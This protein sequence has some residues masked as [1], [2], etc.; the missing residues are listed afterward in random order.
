MYR[1][2]YIFPLILFLIASCSEKQTPQ[3]SSTAH[4]PS[5]SQAAIAYQEK[6]KNKFSSEDRAVM[7]KASESLAMALPDPGLKIGESAPDFTLPDPTGQPVSLSSFLKEG[8]VVLVFYRGA[9]CPYCNMHLLVLNKSLSEFRRLGAQMIAVT[10]QMP[11]KSI[12]QF[13]EEGYPFIVLSDLDSNVM[14]A[15]RLFY[16][17]DPE[18]IKVYK[19]LGLSLEDFNGPGRN[20]LPVPGTFVLDRNGVVRAR[21][22][23]TDYTKRMEP[24]DIVEAL[25]AL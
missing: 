25:K 4:L 20:V 22:V 1:L 19:K 16:E 18:L 13:K 12:K 17:V 9:W 10:P 21:Y 3:Q 23:D 2:F 7:R 11:D 14:K 15:Y 6:Q 24:A 5:Y 8:P